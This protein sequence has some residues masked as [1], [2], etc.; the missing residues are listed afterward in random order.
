MASKRKNVDGRSAAAKMAR[1]EAK[2]IEDRRQAEVL[3]R[4]CRREIVEG[5]VFDILVA[6]AKGD[7][8]PDG[9]HAAIF[10]AIGSGK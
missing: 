1:I 4:R 3:A 8:T 6:V 9:A 5:I 7:C 2:A 10:A